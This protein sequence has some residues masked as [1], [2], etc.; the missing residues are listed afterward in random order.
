[1]KATRSP[2]AAGS[3]LE[4]A[5]EGPILELW[6]SGAAGRYRLKRGAHLVGRIASCPVHL[7]DPKISRQQAELEVGPASVLVRDLGSINGTFLNGQP[8]QRTQPLAEGD[9]LTFA[10][11]SFTV[12]FHRAAGPLRG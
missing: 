9:V 3:G 12:S 2:H 4:P 8:V 5:N 10:E 11:S 6:L 7:D 1:M